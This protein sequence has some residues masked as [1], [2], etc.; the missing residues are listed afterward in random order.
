MRASIPILKT[1][2]IAALLVWI[3]S[4][5]L[6]WILRDG[7]GPGSVETGWVRGGHKFLVD[8]GG[9]ALALILPLIGLSILERR[10]APNRSA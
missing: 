2:L 5:P 6:A 1:L 7:L 4:A 3:L 8:W 9:P 10:L